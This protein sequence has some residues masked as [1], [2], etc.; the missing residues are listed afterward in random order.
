MVNNVLPPIQGAV[1]PHQT[2]LRSDH[3]FW[4]TCHGHWGR[5]RGGRRTTIVFEGICLRG[6]L[7][8]VS[9]LLSHGASPSSVNS[10]TNCL[11][12]VSLKV[13]PETR[14]WV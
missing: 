1:L 9:W 11:V 7:C 13:D 12:W 10:V 6:G 14:I 4:P 8:M 3:S 2:V 5:I